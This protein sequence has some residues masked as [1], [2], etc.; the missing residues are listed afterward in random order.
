[1][2]QQLLSEQL[3]SVYAVYIAHRMPRPAS[4]LSRCFVNQSLLLMDDG[5][6]NAFSGDWTVL[7]FAE[8]TA[9]GIAWAVIL[10]TGDAPQRHQAWNF[11][12][13]S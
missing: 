2:A 9:Q 1:M 7:R 3:A 6:I 5:R 10:V 4:L 8:G 12:R 13:R 11:Y